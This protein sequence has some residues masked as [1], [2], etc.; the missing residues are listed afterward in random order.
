MDL[1]SSLLSPIQ[2]AISGQVSSITSTVTNLNRP[3]ITTEATLSLILI[4]AGLG[5]GFTVGGSAAKSVLSPR[6]DWGGLIR[7]VVILGAAGAALYLLLQTSQVNQPAST[8]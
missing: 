7:P 4:G 2:S 8:T 3:V 5:L 6:P 1:F